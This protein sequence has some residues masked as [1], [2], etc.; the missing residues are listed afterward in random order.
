MVALCL[1]FR[2]PPPCGTHGKRDV[3]ANPRNLAQRP[4][5]PGVACG[6]P[7]RGAPADR[8][9]RGG[10]EGRNQQPTTP[11][12]PA[13]TAP[14]KEEPLNPCRGEQCSPGEFDDNVRLPGRRGRRPLQKNKNKQ[15]KIEILRLRI[16]ECWPRA[17]ASP[18]ALGFLRET[19]RSAARAAKRAEPFPLS[20]ASRAIGSSGHFFGSFLVSKRN[21]SRQKPIKKGSHRKVVTPGSASAIAIS[22]ISPLPRRRRSTR[23]RPP[24]DAARPANITA[25][26]R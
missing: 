10:R 13:V 4:N 3:G 26:R 17:G 2:G 12:S 21:T 22:P 16:V 5:R 9:V 25:E 6:S 18:S 1:R 19:A 11:Q 14:L 15:Q 20:R 7:R 24:H 8:R 23:P